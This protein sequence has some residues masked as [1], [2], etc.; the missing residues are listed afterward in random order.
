MLVSFYFDTNFEGIFKKQKI[1]L[2]GWLHYIQ[3]VS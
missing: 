3:Y 1:R 2:I